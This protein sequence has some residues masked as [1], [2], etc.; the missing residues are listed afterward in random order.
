MTIS[1]YIN[2]GNYDKALILIE[3]IIAKNPNDEKKLYEKAIV[4]FHL[5][6]LDEAEEIFLH[7]Y[8]TNSKSGHLLF[9]MALVTQSLHKTKKAFRLFELAYENGNNESIY[10][11]LN[12]LFE[13]KGICD[14]ANCSDSCCKNTLLKGIDAKRIRSQE[15]FD[16][17]MANPETNSGWQKKSE[18]K[19]GEWIF[20]CKHVDKNNFCS[21]YNN[22]PQICKD[23]PSGILS[24]KSACSY[25]FEL[26]E[27]TPKFSSAKT[28][29]V[30]IDI[31]KAYKYTKEIKVLEERQ[32]DINS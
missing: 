13:R 21:V 12:M 3:E 1:D 19:K 2:T 31:L 9:S 25:Y 8:K 7:L 32:F 14:Y 22:R 20:E 24:L 30:I 16:R 27:K 4:L 26:K 28:Y 6:R 23:F 10:K 17:L 15:S 11:I 18:N 29:A 5:N